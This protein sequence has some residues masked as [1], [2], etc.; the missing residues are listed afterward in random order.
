M[1]TRRVCLALAVVVLAASVHQV[2]SVTTIAA[3]YGSRFEKSM[4][5]S[6]P[7]LDDVRLYWTVN[8]RLQDI[9]LALVTRSTGWVGLGLSDK[10]TMRGADIAILQQD[11]T[12][13]EF[14]VGDYYSK[15]FVTPLR[16]PEHLQNFFLLDVQRNATHTAFHIKRKVRC[17]RGSKDNPNCIPATQFYGHHQILTCDDNDVAISTAPMFVMYALGH[18]GAPQQLQYHRSRGSSRVSFFIKE[19]LKEEPTVAADHV[20]TSAT[21]NSSNLPLNADTFALDLT[22]DQVADYKLPSHTSTTYACFQFDLSQQLGT[23]PVYMTGFAGL[24]EHDPYIHHATFLACSAAGFASVGNAVDECFIMP[25][26]CVYA[27]AWALGVEYQALPDGV[28]SQLGGAACA[29][30]SASADE[31]KNKFIMQLH[32]E[33]PARVDGGRARFGLRFFLRSQPL[34]HDFGLYRLS[35]THAAITVPPGATSSVA[36]ECPGECTSQLPP[37]GINVFVTFLHAHK[38]GQSVRLRHVRDGV[39]LEALGSVDV[40][41]FNKQV[42]MPTNRVL[43]PGDRLLLECDYNASA[44]AVETV[45]GFGSEDESEFTSGAV[46]QR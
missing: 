38:T 40:F 28:A 11:T 41:D 5:L 14:Q 17:G 20:F 2:R 26:E 24:H 19:L 31:C 29:D 1:A 3:D 12:S 44:K 10:G 27:G 34:H 8:Q 15:D 21:F 9:H 25:D 16:D 45:G 37:G 33:N 32:Y 42:A 30:P 22:V 4:V 7:E 39:E 23:T 43:L 13:G 6:P 46:V 35:A 18:D 36:M